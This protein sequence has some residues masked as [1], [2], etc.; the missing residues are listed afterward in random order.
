MSHTWFFRPRVF[1]NPGF[2]LV[3]RLHINFFIYFFFKLIYYLFIFLFIYL[4]IYT[5]IYLFIHLFIYFFIHLFIHL[6]IYSFIYS[7]IYSLIYLYIHEHHK[8][9]VSLAQ[10]LLLLCALWCKK[11]WYMYHSCGRKPA[12]RRGSFN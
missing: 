8:Q 2:G 7:Y 3:R 10:L 11:S 5:F 12:R 9:R 1:F 6:F 4:F